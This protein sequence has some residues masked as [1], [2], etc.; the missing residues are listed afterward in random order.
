MGPPPAGEHPGDLVLHAEPDPRQVDG[1]DPGP[2]LL[3]VFRGRRLRS[4]DPCIVAGAVQA[5]VGP[6][7]RFDQCLYLR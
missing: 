6:D 1:E 7:G 5:A 2:D 3:R 4:V